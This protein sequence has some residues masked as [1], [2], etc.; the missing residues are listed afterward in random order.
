M[1]PHTSG[2]LADEEWMLLLPL[3][4]NCLHGWGGG[5][6]LSPAACLLASLGCDSLVLL[7]RPG[8]HHAEA[9]HQV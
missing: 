9:A 4:L 1:V 3:C 7:C 2:V 6:L 8:L 5:E